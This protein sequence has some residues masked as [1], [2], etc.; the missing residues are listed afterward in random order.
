MT[1][2]RV[3]TSVDD[4]LYR[5]ITIEEQS[6]IPELDI[7]FLLIGFVYLFFCFFLIYKNNALFFFSLP[8]FFLKTRSTRLIPLP[9]TGIL[10]L[11]LKF[12]GNILL[13]TRL[14]CISV[15]VWFT[16]MY[17]S[18]WLLMPYVT[19][20]LGRV[21]TSADLGEETE[22][23]KTVLATPIPFSGSLKSGRIVEVYFSSLI[24]ID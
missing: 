4:S 18:A 2:P 22:K 13:G 7:S 20:T 21:A 9:V 5:A 17:V 16:W 14:I 8:L 6:G 1:F 23:I 24:D 3:H 11:G 10:Y 15:Y 12:H 19:Y